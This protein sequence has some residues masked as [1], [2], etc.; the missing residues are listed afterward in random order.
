MSKKGGKKKGKLKKGATF[1]YAPNVTKKVPGP[2]N[3]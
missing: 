1:G 3:K 2:V